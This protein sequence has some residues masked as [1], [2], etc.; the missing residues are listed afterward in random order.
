MRTGT[1]NTLKTA[2]L[3]AGLGGLLVWLGSVIFGQAGIVLGLLLGLAVVGGSYWFLA[4]GKLD[5]KTEESLARLR[6]SVAG[7]AAEDA[8]DL[9]GFLLAELRSR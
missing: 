3:L 1:V 9:P 5:A 2:V 8:S 6:E 7:L 4:F